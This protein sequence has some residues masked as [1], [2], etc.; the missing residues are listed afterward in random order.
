M[1]NQMAIILAQ[2]LRFIIA[3]II[4]GFATLTVFGQMSA[5]TYSDLWADDNGNLY[6]CGVTDEGYNTYSHQARV[7]TTLTSPNSRSSSQDTGYQGSYACA[8]VYLSFDESDIGMFN[9]SSDHIAYCP[10]VFQEISYGSTFDSGTAATGYSITWW[11]RS[12]PSSQPGNCNYNK[13]ASCTASCAPADPWSRACT[14]LY[15]RAF[16]SYV[17]IL[18]KKICIPPNDDQETTS[19]FDSCGDF[20]S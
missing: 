10:V 17:S 13:V 19:Q 12:T 5:Y 20:S 3:V 1:R 16:R 4:C 7:I 18:G 14:T 6:G 9:L 2:T 8:T 11:R 15:V